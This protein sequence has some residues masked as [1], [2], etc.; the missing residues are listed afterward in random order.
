MQRYTD[1]DRVA[2]VTGSDS[3]IGEA[4]AVAL[5][6]AGFDVDMPTAAALPGPVHVPAAT[7]A[8]ELPVVPGAAHNAITTAGTEVAA[9]AGAFVSR[10][11]TAAVTYASTSAHRAGWWP[12]RS[13]GRCSGPD[14]PR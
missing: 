14:R 4:I 6:G 8:A 7:P 13:A 11:V 9:L 12:R 5:T 2:V 10:G 1:Y 3:G